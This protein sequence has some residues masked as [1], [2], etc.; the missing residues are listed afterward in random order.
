[1]VIINAGN[2]VLNTHSSFC[3]WNNFDTVIHLVEVNIPKINYS[4]PGIQ[5]SDG[6]I[7]IIKLSILLKAICGFNA[8][9]IKMLMAYFTDLEQIFQKCI[10]TERNP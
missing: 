1:M 7:N 9:A 10:W 8:N 4:N 6:W 5:Y 2:Y 3:I